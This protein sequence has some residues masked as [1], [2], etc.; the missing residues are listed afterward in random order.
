MKSILSI[1]ITIIEHYQVTSTINQLS[2]A[3][4]II[5][6]GG[7]G[8]LSKCYTHLAFIDGLDSVLTILF[9]LLLLLLPILLCVMRIVSTLL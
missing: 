7:W 1:T 6:V 3:I 8:T 2:S 9:N 4:S 5:V